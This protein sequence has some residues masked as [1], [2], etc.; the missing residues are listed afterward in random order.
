[1][2]QIRAYRGLDT[3]LLVD[4]LQSLAA[5][6][7]GDVGDAFMALVRA[8]SGLASGDLRAAS[9]NATRNAEVWTQGQVEGYRIA[10]RAALWA[11]DV[12]LAQ[13]GLEGFERLK[14]HGRAVHITSLTFSGGI[15][16]L[17]GRTGIRRG[18]Y[19]P[20]PVRR[21][22]APSRLRPLFRPAVGRR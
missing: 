3:D 17:E 6:F 22:G 10:T 15:A 12:Q 13:K 19:P 20:Q 8:Y 1:M 21:A 16:A 14:Q 7:D 9:A 4:E 5:T 2:Q 11:R 18:R